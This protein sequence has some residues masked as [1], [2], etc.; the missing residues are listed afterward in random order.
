MYQ[1]KFGI[2]YAEGCDCHSGADKV[3]TREVHPPIVTLLESE[4]DAV[5]THIINM[6]ITKGL[7]CGSL[8][9]RTFT[10]F[11]STPQLK[12]EPDSMV[13]LL[14]SSDCLLSVGCYTPKLM[15]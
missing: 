10:N 6:E 5:D 2:S 11:P 1:A 14:L 4:D 9:T 7:D 8:G 15:M 13:S 12:A 3:T